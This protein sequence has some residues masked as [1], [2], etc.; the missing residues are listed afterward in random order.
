MKFNSFIGVLLLF[1]AAS[2]SA[3]KETRHT[4]AMDS[5]NFLLDG[6]PYQIISGEMHYARI[7]H[8]YW[9]HRIQMA[10]AMGCNTIATY[11]F[12]N[13]H[14]TSEGVFDFETENRNLAEY[15]E[16]AKEEGMW[17]LLRPGPYACAEWDLGGIPPYL[18]SIPDIKL[19]CMDTRYM[20]AVERYVQNL[21]AV[22]KPYLITNGGNVIMLQVENEYGSY[23]NDRNYMN[24]MKNLWSAQGIDVPFYTSDGATEYML[25]AGALPGCAVGLDPCGNMDDYNLARKMNP[26]VPVFG[27]E[28]YPGWLTHWGEEWQ[29]PDT[30]DL[31]N[32]VRF[33][34]ENKISFNLYVLHGGTNFDFYAGANSGGTGYQPDITSYDYDAPINEQGQPTPKYFALQKEILK[35]KTK[36]EKRFKMPEPVPAMEIP[37]IAMT[38]FASVWNALPE[39]VLSVQPK[40]FE[41]Y[42]LYY[43]FAVYKTTL[44]G[45]KSGNLAITDLH[46]Y[47]TVF[48]DGKF[49]GT[50]DRS[51]G[52][53]SIKLPASESKNPVLEIFVEGMGR[54]NF[55]QQLIDRKGITERAT[56][57]GMTL[58]NWEVYC[59]PMDSAYIARLDNTKSENRPGKF[60][61]GTFSLEKTADT[62]ID[63]SQYTK[64]V[65]WVNGHNLG[66]YWNIGPQ[67][68]LYCPAPF[69][70]EGKNEIII[71]DLLQMDAKSVTGKKNLY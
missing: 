20:A 15:L 38:E 33:L 32:N 56:L 57:N 27:S 13:Y 2:L 30:A 51:K 43:G 10:K 40:P 71:L 24:A 1:S 49:V 23:G 29:R 34:L 66:R 12:W 42:N 28:I 17:V 52:E 62:F 16:I 63:M 25:E 44:I 6:K 46:D 11:V 22:V 7:P 26:G 18:L 36:S 39:P 3:Q 59:L 70:E 55:A 68:R 47:A 35:Y 4:F 50:I 37:E 9:R 61:K 67:Q 41:A 60:F 53:T 69:L 45:H 54:I 14:E 48:L 65:V 19:R 31:L 64:G 8:E 21:A 5:V 58:M